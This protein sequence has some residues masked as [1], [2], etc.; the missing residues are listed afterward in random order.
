[1]TDHWI[2]F[3][4][5]VALA[6][7]AVGVA[8]GVCDTV[9]GGLILASLS[10][11][12]EA[13]AYTKLAISSASSDHSGPYNLVA[14]ISWTTFALTAVLL[15][16]NLHVWTPLPIATSLVRSAGGLSPRHLE[17]IVMLN[18]MGAANALNG[19]AET[20][21]PSCKQFNTYP[22]IGGSDAN[23]TAHPDQHAGHGGS[24]RA[25]AA[26]RTQR[27]Q[28]ASTISGEKYGLGASAKRPAPYRGKYAARRQELLIGNTGRISLYDRHRN[29]Y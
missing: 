6:L 24:S 7:I 19:A 11:L 16:A 2:G 18:E 13:L 12:G 21:S 25:K 8:T 10:M 26:S 5:A 4:P 28:A 14:G 9:L 22:P 1:M 20:E 15:L 23:A 3:V 29:F 27:R 17:R